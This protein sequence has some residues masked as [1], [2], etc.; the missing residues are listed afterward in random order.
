M[1]YFLSVIQSVYTDGILRSV[2]TDG[3]TDRIFRIKKRRFADVEVF[4]GD[5]TDGITEGFK[6]EASYSDM[7]NLPLELPI[8]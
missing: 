3:I 4:A 2:Y 6:S 8:E 7:I 1:E 5:F